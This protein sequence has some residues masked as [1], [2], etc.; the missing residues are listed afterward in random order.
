[1]ANNAYSIIDLCSPIGDK[2][3]QCLWHGYL[4]LKFVI[5]FEVEG[6]FLFSFSQPA[7]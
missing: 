4:L 6:T 7:Y 5:R 1:L 2:W 3:K